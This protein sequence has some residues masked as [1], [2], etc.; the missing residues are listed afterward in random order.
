M[1][2]KVLA[3]YNIPVGSHDKYNEAHRCRLR[4]QFAGHNDVLS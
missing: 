3:K 4:S 1:Q 2:I